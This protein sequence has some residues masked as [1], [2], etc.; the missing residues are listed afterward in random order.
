M[1]KHLTGEA[2]KA[3]RSSADI[4]GG[5]Y[6]P[7]LSLMYRNVEEGKRKPSR[8]IVN[9]DRY[10]LSMLATRGSAQGINAC[11]GVYRRHPGGV[12]SSITT[13]RRHLEALRSYVT[14]AL[15]IPNEF[16]ADIAIPLSI[17]V[18]NAWLHRDPSGGNDLYSLLR[19]GYL[20]SIVTPMRTTVSLRSLRISVYCAV[21]PIIRIIKR[22]FR[23]HRASSPQY[24]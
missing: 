22:A 21:F 8:K 6:I 5:C 7:T 19:E 24:Q 9:A 15:D 12:W 14:I 20:L 10:L 1:T 23:D 4:L 17:K 11:M 16:A 2:F 13:A 3:E 18:T